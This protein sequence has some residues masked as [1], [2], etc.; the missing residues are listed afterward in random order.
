MKVAIFKSESGNF[1]KYFSVLTEHGYEIILIPSLDFAYKNISLLKQKLIEA[2]DQYSGIIFTS[3]RAVLAVKESLEDNVPSF[4]KMWT[5]KRNYSVGETTWLSVKEN[6]NLETLGKESGNA[7][8]LS[9]IIITDHHNEP[10][11]LPFL[12]PSSNLKQDTLQ[13]NLEAANIKLDPVESYETVPHPALRV[14][15][16]QVLEDQ[17]VEAFVFFSPSGV[18]FSH[19]IAIEQNKLEELRR[20]KLIAIGPSTKRA[21]EGLGFDVF[22]TAEIPSPEGLLMALSHNKRKHEATS[23]TPKKQL[24]LDE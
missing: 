7:Q 17:V 6:L 24:A 23:S 11:P 10:S 13:K 3:P 20:K 5:S 22:A 1:S 16:L 4:T 14:N 21:I 12:F 2:S 15:L 9:E 19:C 8:K 18:N